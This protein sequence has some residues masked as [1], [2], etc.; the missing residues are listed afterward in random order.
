M[1]KKIT[2]K[3]NVSSHQQT[4]NTSLQNTKFQP[5][6]LLDEGSIYRC[7]ARVWVSSRFLI[8]VIPL[9]VLGSNWRLHWSFTHPW[10]NS[11]R[12]VSRV[13]FLEDSMIIHL[14][15]CLCHLS[16]LLI[17]PHKR[18]FQYASHLASLAVSMHCTLPMEQSVWSILANS[19]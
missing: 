2:Q 17:A 15:N 12:Q 7:I 5:L 11:E 13:K 18:P 14:A 10:A 6:D 3:C 4:N 1:N 16:I 8:S 19:E 9:I